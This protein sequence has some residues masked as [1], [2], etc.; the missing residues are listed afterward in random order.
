M[1][2]QFLINPDTLV[3]FILCVLIV[4][5]CIIGYLRIHTITPLVIG[6][7]FFLFGISHVA[8]LL[9]R[10]TSLEPMVTFLRVIGYIAICSGM[11]LVI[12]EIILRIKTENELTAER[13]GL[14]QRVNERTKELQESN[15]V[16]IAS[17]EKL[18]ESEKKYRTL[19]E[20]M[21]EGVAY[22]R[23]IYDATGR[24]SGWIYLEVND[25]FRRI[26][27]I[28]DITGKRMLEAMPDIREQ[29]PELLDWYER[30]VST[31]TPEAVE[32]EFPSLKTWLKIS[33]FSPE[34]EHFVLVIWDITK[35]KQAERAQQETSRHL[36]DIIDFL[37]D[38]TF[39]VDITG[40]VI[41]WNHAMETM[42]GIPAGDILGKGTG[43]TVT[44]IRNYPGPLLIDYTLRQDI[45]GIK[46]AFPNARFEGNVTRIMMTVTRVDQVQFSLWVSATPLID[47]NGTV[48]GAIESLR[49][50][51][52][53]K[54]IER[55]LRESNT[56][57]DAII[58]TIA[59][60]V[61]IKNRR[62]RYVTVND[63]FCQYIGHTREE[64]IGRTG[65]DFFAEDEAVVFQIT[66][67]NVFLTGVENEI[68]ENI[69]DSQGKTYTVSTKKSRYI[70]AAGE[71]FI[72]GIIRDI[73][74]RKETELALQQALEKLGMLSSITRHDILNQL[75]GLRGY[76]GL[77]M[78]QEK[79]SEIIRFLQKADES[80]D[81]I[82]EQL[83]F[84]R[85][86]E[87][88]GIQAPRWQ[89]VAAVFR[90]A[91]SQLPLDGIDI[92]TGVSGLFIH[93]DPLIGKVF[94]TLL[95]NTCR[96][97][98]AVTSISL[99]NE[100]TPA[101]LVLTY[102]DN[103]TGIAA[104]DKSRLFTRGFGK[105]TGLGLFLSRE[106]LAITSM[107][108]SE[109]GE[110]GKGVQFEISVPVGAYRFVP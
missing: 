29:I 23:L 82:R 36:A 41:A 79:D 98:G 68:E 10:G 6:A 102:R 55:E 56:Y 105:H 26:T 52:H 91:V 60:P 80:G 19:F 89:D 95:E 94:Y 72:V 39:V 40:E 28:E 108:I 63:R 101:G 57:L 27:G 31:G 66:D 17:D 30:V 47:S 73:T 83:E 25:A 22:C 97:G 20:N 92:D 69:T 34:K 54:M 74:K 1:S 24:P 51:T 76:L 32:T 11:Y 37:P 70:N 71:E 7:G 88:L 65:Y 99:S 62:Q 75:T 21:L 50:V 35:R 43:S 87:D 42:S 18:R 100:E 86:Y 93:A 58:N 5:I 15:R 14:E 4:V 84:A 78:K 107:T 110:P 104:E 81:A 8:T 85:D 45:E 59:D 46:S 77:A 96:H 64:L 109:S 48:T 9:D 16:L 13:L 103:G 67:E 44:W 38:P 49:D 3:N 2:V 12:R 53:L 90:S 61:F 33:V 106:I